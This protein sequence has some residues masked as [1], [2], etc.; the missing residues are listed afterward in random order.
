MPEVM[1]PGDI[2]KITRIF[3]A[4]EGEEFCI[5]RPFDEAKDDQTNCDNALT[6]LLE[7]MA[8]PTVVPALHLLKKSDTPRPDGEEVKTDHIFMNLGNLAYIKVLNIVVY[9]LDKEEKKQ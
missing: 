8:K 7:S 9:N 5:D 1:V 2:K 6:L 3:F 4:F